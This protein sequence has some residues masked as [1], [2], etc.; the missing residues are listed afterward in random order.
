MTPHSRQSLLVVL[1]LALVCSLGWASKRQAVIQQR[2]SESYALPK[3]YRQIH[4]G[5]MVFCYHRVLRNSWSTR[6]IRHLSNNSQLH[7]FNVPTD[8]FAYQM[9]YLHDHHIAVISASTMTKMIAHHQPIHGKYVVLSFDDIDRTVVDNAIPVMIKY[10]LPF[11]TFIITGN[12]GDYREG[13]QMATWSEI[14]RAKRQAGNLMTLGL[15]T[16][17]MHYL[18]AQ[19]HPVFTEP[20]MMPRFRRDF[21]KSRHELIKHTGVQATSFAYPYG[22]STTQTNK[23]LAHQKLGWVATLDAGV[24]TSQTSLNETPRLIINQ[25]SWPSVRNWLT[26]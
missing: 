17:D 3:Q 19:G 10:R 9:A 5:I 15:H 1:M 22:A 23:Y 25:E 14:N 8:Q 18:N 16:H 21:A 4:N 20:H 11:T 24:V 6:A 12:T 7:Q 13:S 26:H 2:S